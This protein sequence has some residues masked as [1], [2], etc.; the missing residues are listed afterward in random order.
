MRDQLL[1][2]LAEG[3][4]DTMIINRCEIDVS[5][6]YGMKEDGEGEGLAYD[7]ESASVIRLNN[8]MILYLREVNNYL[9]LV[10]LLREE[11]FTKQGECGNVMSIRL[12]N[13]LYT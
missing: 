12:V 3:F 9:A 8:G 10:C 2:H 11:N 4:K 13:V 1:H 5:C 6:I 7:S